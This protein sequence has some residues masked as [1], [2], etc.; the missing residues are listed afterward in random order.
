MIEKVFSTLQ[1]GYNSY[2]CFEYCGRF[3]VKPIK[4]D[5]N[6]EMPKGFASKY[7]STHNSELLEK[8]ADDMVITKSTFET[9]DISVRKMD[10]FPLYDFTDDSE[11]L[12]A[13]TILKD[14]YLEGLL[15]PILTLD[16]TIVSI[17]RTKACGFI[18]NQCGYRSKGD[19]IDA[20]YISEMWHDDVLKEIPL[21]K[22]AGKIES[23]NRVTYL[24][25][26]KQRTF[27]IEPIGLYFHHKRIYGAQ[28][29]AMRGCF[30]SAYG[31]NPYE[32]GVNKLANRLMKHR[33]F[34][35]WDAVRWD[36]KAAWMRAV[37]TLKN[38][39][40]PEDKFKEWVTEHNVN[41]HLVLPNG[42]LIYKTWGN[43][44]GSGSTT[45]DNILGMSLIII[46]ALLRLSKG[47]P[48]IV[49]LVEA[50][51]FGDDVVGS[52]SIN[53]SDEEFEK[54]FRETFNMYG[55]ELDPFIVTRDIERLE[56]LGFRFKN[57]GGWYGPLY[58]LGT[59]AKSFLYSVEKIS[60]D[61][62]ISKM[63]SL[64]MMSAGHGLEIYTVFRDALNEVITKS[65]TDLAK[66]LARFGVPTHDEALEFYRGGFE[67]LNVDM[68]NILCDLSFLHGGGY[69]T[70]G[71][72][73]VQIMCND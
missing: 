10:N 53:C 73:E 8:W 4:D 38:M 59:L 69:Y 17:D 6:Y 42:D 54:V 32:G 18:E 7:V 5:F 29:I 16:E 15:C 2:K 12:K 58:N 44:S 28:S 23:E 31:F 49:D 39:C 24:E 64:L 60:R 3:T 40:L 35:M 63:L 65:E 45:V 9:L 67:G 66:R 13:C 26:H 55:H 20:G 34:W 68:S 30:W 62:E 46:H 52:D 61:G 19:W 71:G 72:E 70:N 14:R 27:I 37:Y 41:S 51:C 33:R 47:D 48:N 56:F 1:E 21:W 25:D 22:V 57:L 43:N 11:Y 36:R 50:A